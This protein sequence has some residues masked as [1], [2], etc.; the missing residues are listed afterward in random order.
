MSLFS[1]KVR[2]CGGI[3]G[4]LSNLTPEL[5]AD[6]LPQKD[7]PCANIE[8]C[9]GYTGN[10]ERKGRYYR[11][12]INRIIILYR[13][14]SAHAKMRM[15]H[16]AR[17]ISADA[18]NAKAHK[19]I[20]L[21]HATRPDAKPA[22]LAKAK[23]SVSLRRYIQPV[24]ILIGNLFAAKK[25]MMRRKAWGDSA[26]GITSESGETF[27]VVAAVSG[28]SCDTVETSAAD[29]F[30]S[31]ATAKVGTAE[32][33]NAEVKSTFAMRHGAKAVAWAY[34]EVVDGY[35]IIRQAYE[36]TPIGVVL[37]VV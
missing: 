35:L 1:V 9:T 26:V 32:I 25:V 11:G 2:R 37:E 6:I 14:I 34:P 5:H 22:T 4:K 15:G 28:C 7:A 19:G 23:R 21:G 16:S 10:W 20:L 24:A 18:N 33:C 13:F 27:S 12:A 3:Y 30:I 31:K 29:C 36:A 17:L 8:S